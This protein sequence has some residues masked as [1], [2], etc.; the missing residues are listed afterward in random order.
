MIKQN[1]LLLFSFI[2]LDNQKKKSNLLQ[3]KTWRFH[4]FVWLVLQLLCVEFIVQNSW[5][6]WLTAARTLTG[7]KQISAGKNQAAVVVVAPCGDNVEMLELRFRL[8]FCKKK[9]KKRGNSFIQ[10]FL[11]IVADGQSKISYAFPDYVPCLCLFRAAAVIKF[12]GL[13]CT[14]W[15]LLSLVFTPDH[16]HHKSN[17]TP[18]KL[19]VPESKLFSFFLISSFL[20]SRFV[21]QCFLFILLTSKSTCSRRRCVSGPCELYR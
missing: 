12:P 15:C 4:L 11:S 17:V 3:V 2:V 6:D 21:P 16:C 9:K 19:R 20:T 14:F 5:G 7:E 8:A 1:N 13:L 10:R 18:F